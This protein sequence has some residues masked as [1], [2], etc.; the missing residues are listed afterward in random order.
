MK[1]QDFPETVSEIG[2]PLFQS[3]IGILREEIVV[4]SSSDIDAAIEITGKTGNACAIY[5]VA[6][7]ALARHGVAIAM[8][9]YGSADPPFNIELIDRR[10][11][12]DSKVAVPIDDH[13]VL[14]GSVIVNHERLTLS[15]QA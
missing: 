11:L 9:A 13:S 8:A 4:Q 12:A 1:L 5:A 2:Y 15:R 6:A 3:R 7:D 10:G 14:R